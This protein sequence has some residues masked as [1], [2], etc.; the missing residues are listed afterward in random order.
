MRACAGGQ[1]IVG[2]GWDV[3][4]NG[5][6]GG[7]DSRIKGFALGETEGAADSMKGRRAGRKEGEA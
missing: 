4:R 7:G 1:W 3:L 6:R 2:T 5:E